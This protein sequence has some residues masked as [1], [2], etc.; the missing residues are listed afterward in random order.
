LWRHRDD[1][2]NYLS[3]D[4]NCGNLIEILKYGA[5]CGGKTSEEFS[6]VLRRTWH[7]NER[8]HRMKLS[9]FVVTFFQKIFSMRFMK[10]DFSPFLPTKQQIEAISNSRVLWY[11][12]WTRCIASEKTFLVSSH[13]NRV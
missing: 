11:L 9:I 2:S 10:Q 7:T 13:A 5:S 6:K 1:S 3:T 12:L 8:L 4:V